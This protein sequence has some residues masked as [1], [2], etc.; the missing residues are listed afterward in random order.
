MCGIAG[1]LDFSFHA[2][3]PDQL[4]DVSNSLKHRGPDSGGCWFEK[5]NILGLA[6]RRLSILD[7]SDAGAQP[8]VSHC[9]RYVIVYNGEIYNFSE[10]RVKLEQSGGQTT[11]AGHSDT[12]VLLNGVAKWGID[13]C[14]KFCRGMFAFAIW[15][16]HSRILSL[17]RDRLGEKPLYFFSSGSKFLFASELKALLKFK[18]IQ[19]EI[20][21]ESLSLFLQFSYVPAPLSIFK[22][23]KK[24]MPGQ[25]VEINFSE[26]K[27]NFRTYWDIYE[28]TKIKHFP[29]PK[30]EVR[31][32]DQVERLLEKSVS[33]QM[34]AD[35]PVGAFLSGG[36]D[37]SLIT[38][39]M[40]KN[41]DLP[42]NTYTI[43]YEDE[44]YDE[45]VNARLT[46][47]KI[48]TNHHELFL[49][50]KD[51][52]ATV[53]KIPDI[54]DEPFADSSQIPTYLLSEFAKT[55]LKV[56]L[57]GDGGDELFSGYNRHVFA[58]T[59]WNSI[60]KVPLIVRAIL[61]GSIS[62]I[63]PNTW[64]RIYGVLGHFIDEEKKIRLPGEKFHKLADS[65]I[66]RNIEEL[67]MN[68]TQQS[69]NVR[70]L[71]KGDIANFKLQNVPSHLTD[72]QKMMFWDQKNY[73]PNDILTKVDRASMH[74]SLE[75][76]T[77]FLDHEVVEYAWSLPERERIFKGNGKHI[78]RELLKKYLG[79]DFKLGSKM[80]FG[81]PLDK[82]FRIEL[83]DWAGD[84]LAESHIQQQGIFCS[85]TVNRLWQDHLSERQN[86]HHQIWNI[87]VFQNWYDS[88][89][90]GD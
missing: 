27:T 53:P 62:N 34:V 39:L 54:Y 12:E 26:R 16:R 17:A 30:L 86:C 61:A 52:L 82:W 51:L 71:K 28:C 85:K 49:S 60:Q 80:G 58:S 7:L 4:Q 42:I 14:L 75:V 44:D 19:K 21:L 48:G 36:V 29:N 35:V 32:I 24:L 89:L 41:R 83:R 40:Q 78:L 72:A 15:D 79:D 65:L 13:R 74:V 45:A 38:C 50:P 76:R 20:D 66:S 77:P 31:Y 33:Q 56:C 8:M 90:A 11:W 10:L 73:L 18:S 3:L 63:S 88:I 6:H 9:G 57:S 2:G 47:K 70:F 84:M 43:G 22:D 81:V 23:V 5:D 67:Y 68:L 25:I 1:F 59:R 46:S 69:R 37:S 55:D 87:L 64:G